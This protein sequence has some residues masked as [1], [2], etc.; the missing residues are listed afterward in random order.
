METILF[1]KLSKY[2]ASY[3]L[4]SNIYI[5]LG[6]CVSNVENILVEIIGDAK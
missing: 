6:N 4:L 3:V 5:E 2:V 1:F